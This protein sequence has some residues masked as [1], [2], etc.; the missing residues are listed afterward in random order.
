MP[1]CPS[2]ILDI[3]L[4]NVDDAHG[5][6][7]CL[8]LNKH[9]FHHAATMLYADPLLTF[10]NLDSS[11]KRRFLCWLLSISHTGDDFINELRAYIGIEHRPFREHAAAAIDN[12][13]SLP[14][15][16]F[17]YLTFVRILRWHDDNDR[18]CF[19]TLFPEMR[20]HALELGI[21]RSVYH[22]KVRMG[23]MWGICGNQLDRMVEIE[24]EARL[25]E[26]SDLLTAVP[27][28]SGLKRIVIHA[29]P[30]EDLRPFY[31]AAIQFV[32]VFQKHHGEHQLQECFFIQNPLEY[33]RHVFQDAL[34]LYSLLPGRSE[35]H[36]WAAERV[37]SP[38]L[39]LS[40]PS[41]SSLLSG[42]DGRA[43]MLDADFERLDKITL[44]GS[45]AHPWRTLSQVYGDSWSPEDFAR[46]CRHVVDITASFGIQGYWPEEAQEQ[47]RFNQQL[48]RAV[49]ESVP[50]QT[51]LLYLVLQELEGDYSMANSALR[52][53]AETVQSL[54][55]SL[56]LSHTNVDLDDPFEVPPPEASATV[57]NVPLDLPEAM[58][59]LQ[60]VSIH[61]AGNM[62]FDPSFLEL[63]PIQYLD[64]NL[65][66]H[67]TEQLQIVD[68]WSVLH[69]PHLTYL[70]LANGAIDHLDP[71]SFNHMPSL[72]TLILRTFDHS[73]FIASTAT[74]ENGWTW[75][76]H[77]PSLRE[78][79]IISNASH[80]SFNFCLLETC[81]QLT[82]INLEFMSPPP[83]LWN[84]PP[85]PPSTFEQQ[86]R[87]L[88]FPSVKRLRL[89]R[90]WA[91]DNVEM[92]VH[93]LSDLLQTL[94]GLERLDVRILRG[95]R[96]GVVEATRGHPT[97][98][99][100][101]ADGDP[102]DLGNLEGT[103]ADEPSLSTLGLELLSDKVDARVRNG[104]E[105]QDIS[106]EH[107]DGCFYYIDSK[108]YGL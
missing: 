48:A 10:H 32:R 107:D 66:S 93:G 84:S 6:Y 44:G 62:D 11:R 105:S 4:S 56:S 98:G 71:T 22:A 28:L 43:R 12:T 52:T 85:A 15:P 69:L 50:A 13:S 51:L 37:S 64:M 96:A 47:A 97:L 73:T 100:V 19:F 72:K 102:F 20:S 25:L 33:D 38:A 14:S 86:Q 27:Q 57:Q 3:I 39:I 83:H 70:G 95:Y 63:S 26:Y 53:S 75:R 1:S 23:L 35:Q 67:H 18:E 17:D 61:H 24:V 36:H 82:D 91:D 55:L 87:Q 94:T 74:E 78:L 7:A 42:R 21:E 77:L 60:K 99:E 68:R 2:E 104:D 16:L 80:S 89:G 8:P 90:R 59:H 92:N 81:P 45:F 30:R 101:V 54:T 46:K 31:R 41:T 88:Q 58:P 65:N 34:E 108:F 5:H 76:W 49:I 9:S 79:G 40:T 103:D 106:P 29:N